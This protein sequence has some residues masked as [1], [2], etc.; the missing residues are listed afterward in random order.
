MRIKF[1]ASSKG[2]AYVNF[3]SLHGCKLFVG[4]NLMGR[5]SPHRG[6]RGLPTKTVARTKTKVPKP[7]EHYKSFW[8]EGYGSESHSELRERCE[9]GKGE[10][11]FSR[12]GL[13]P[14]PLSSPFLYLSRSSYVSLFTSVR[15]GFKAGC[16]F[17]TYHS[18]FGENASTDCRFPTDGRT[19]VNRV[20]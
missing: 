5:F 9:R 14:F 7:R 19:L 13:A 12:K 10:R 20:A 11:S 8:K 18:F 16:G 15:A 2:D 6:E 17:D 1:V 3:F 4:G